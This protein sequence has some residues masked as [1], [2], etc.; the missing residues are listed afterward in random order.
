MSW[1]AKR[2]PQ[3]H[4]FGVPDR[5]DRLTRVYSACAGKNSVGGHSGQSFIDDVFV[6]LAATERRRIAD[7]RVPVGG[8]HEY[9]ASTTGL[10]WGCAGAVT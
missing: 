7:D 1:K 4:E 10:L 5:K 3:L 8:L 2:F 9:Q 6:R